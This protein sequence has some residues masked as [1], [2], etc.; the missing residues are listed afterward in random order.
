[1]NASG[2]VWNAKE[3]ESIVSD[4][5]DM[6]RMELAGTQFN[7]AERNRV[8]QRRLGRTKGSV[9][10]KRQNISAVMAML[11]L[12]F[13]R[14]YKPAAHFQ[15]LLYEVVEAQLASGGLLERLCS[16]PG[17]IVMPGAAIAW[18]EPPARRRRPENADAAIRRVLDRLDWVGRNARAG[19]LGEA[20]EELLYRAEQNRL[21]SIGRDDLADGV[22]WVSKEE[23]DGAGYDILSFSAAGEKRWLEVK[24]TNGSRLTPFWMTANELRTSKK[25]P[26]CFRLVRLYNFSW[27][28]AAF[29]LRPPLSDHVHLDP[30][31]YRA[32][33]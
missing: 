2:A 25:C 7:K 29:K 8:L 28:P 9:E 19:A 27:A 23:G 16:Q 18:H 17:D 22:R 4:Y 6:L 3:I 31:Q 20:G 10:Y 15:A 1:M 33:F 26:A 24:T 12:P 32:S 14:G 13:I 21:R 30:T 5:L 11:G